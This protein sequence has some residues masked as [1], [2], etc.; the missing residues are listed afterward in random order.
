MKCPNCDEQ[1][2]IIECLEG[3]ELYCQIC[4]NF[5]VNIEEKDKK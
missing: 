5:F 3:L 2:N 4:E 1:D